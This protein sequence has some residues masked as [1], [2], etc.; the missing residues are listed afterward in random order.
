MSD[1]RITAE[2][3]AAALAGAVVL[4]VVGFPAPSLSGAM[5]GV[6]LLLAAGRKARMP[7]PATIAA[8]LCCGVAM[9][10]AVTPEM[11]SGF[12]KYPLSLAVFAAS[13]AATVVLTQAFLR[14]FGGW[15]RLTAFFAATPGALSTVLA[16]AAETRADMLKLTTVQSFRLFVLVAVL[17]VL[18]VA[19]G[20]GEALPPRPDASALGLAAMCA[21]G[22][23]CALAMGRFGM[24]APWIF[25][26]LLGS[27]V[28]HG[29]GLIVGDAPRW[30]TEP[31]FALVG[32]FI[33]TRF[34]TVTRAALA[35]ALGMS[36]GALLI[37]LCVAFASAALLNQMT[38]LPLGMVLV[39]FAPGG[40]EAM[41]VLG[42]SLGLDPIYVGLHHLVRFFGIAF[43]LPVVLPILARMEARG[44]PDRDGT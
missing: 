14:R 28:L 3:F 21:A 10:A 20:G 4:H 16:V 12:R 36:V 17:P 18:V 32:V 13:I 27:A 25:G 34:S 35:S 19:T 29:G 42:A 41:L 39:A 9:G 11:L 22:L 43:A 24:A 2:T 23:A 1:A 26:G 44:V 6:A 8:M 40:L 37:G 38:G 7:E 31:A 15:D 30:F 5:V 33:G